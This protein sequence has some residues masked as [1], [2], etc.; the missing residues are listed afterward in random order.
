MSEGTPESQGGQQPEVSQQEVNPPVAETTEP[1]PLVEGINP[2][3]NDL[4]SDLPAGLHSQVVPHLKKWDQNYQT[5]IEKVHSKYAPFKP[6]VD[7]G[8]DPQ[9]VEWGTNLALGLQSKPGDVINAMVAYARENGI[10]LEEAMEEMEEAAN[11]QGLSNDEVDPQ[12]SQLTQTVQE[13]QSKVQQS[14]QEK[15]EQA[16]LEAIQAEVKELTEKYG[17]FD[18]EWVLTRALSDPSNSIENAVKAF[19]ELEK[20]ILERNQTP[21]RPGAPQVLGPGGTAPTAGNE[22]PASPAER[23]KLVQQMLQQSNQS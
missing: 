10:T 22:A 14:E 16:E 17:E 23:K 18:E 8:I 11:E 19:K 5:G 7:K 1:Q 9:I 15:A 4:L 2:A 21:V 12:I 20:S 3:W 6:F 13:L